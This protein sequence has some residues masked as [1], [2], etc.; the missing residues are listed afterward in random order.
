MFKLTP[1]TSYIEEN[2][3]KIEL[4]KSPADLYDPLRYFLT[5][6]GKR[7]RPVLTLLAAELFGADKSEA[8]PQALCIEVFHNFTLIHDDIMDEAPIRRNQPTIHAKWHQ[9]AAILSGDVLFI[10][11]YQ[12]LADIDPAKLPEAFDLFNKTGI[13]VCEG[14]QYD[15]SFEERDDVSIHEYIEMIRLKTSV[16]L[17]CALT[18]GAIIANAS[19]K[20]KKELYI[21]GENIGIAFQIQDDILDLYADS[22]KFG[23][24]VGGDVMANK[25]TIL[26]LTALSKATK[27]QIEISKQLRNESNIE[28]KVS[29]TRALFDHL[30]VKEECKERMQEHY[31]IALA[32]MSRVSVPE[33]NKKPLLELAKYLMDREI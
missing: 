28:L 6:G 1:Y 30:N 23:K 24:Q 7:V 5:I 8:L 4:P 9:N 26:H 27:E 22:E 32:A 20:D 33:E 2:L 10:K 16:L 18:M 25:K 21:F 12:L 19:E 11:A 15:M 14:Q 3:Q 29:R 17:G 13:A 31:K